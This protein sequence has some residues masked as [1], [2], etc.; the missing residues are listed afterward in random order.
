MVNG[1]PVQ[2]GQAGWTIRD[3]HQF[4]CAYHGDTGRDVS[5]RDLRHGAIRGNGGYSRMGYFRST[6]PSFLALMALILLLASSRALRFLENKGRRT[7]SI[8][9]RQR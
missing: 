4:S 6:N 5:R 9:V 7:G 1:K 3:L 8:A 2:L